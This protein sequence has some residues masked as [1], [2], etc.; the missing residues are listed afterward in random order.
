MVSNDRA[1]D[2]PMEALRAKIAN[3][4]SGDEGETLGV[5][6]N[7]CRPIKK[8]EVEACLQKMVDEGQASVEESIHKFTKKMVKRYIE[9]RR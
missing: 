6:A 1:K 5:I 2:S 9:N 4:I 8:A 3:L 7:K